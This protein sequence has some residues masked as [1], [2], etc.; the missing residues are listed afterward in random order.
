[1]PD[2][3]LDVPTSD[4]T[5][6]T[7]DV[8]GWIAGA[9]T[10]TTTILITRD[11]QAGSRLAAIDTELEQLQQPAPDPEQRPSRRLAE[12]NPNEARIRELHTERDTIAVGMTGG[13]LWVTVRALSYRVND[14]I[15]SDS[16]A[17]RNL[18]ALAAS[19]TVAAT[20]GGPGESLT[21]EQWDRLT[22]AIG[23]A[24]TVR[25]VNALTDLTLN[26]VVTPD[27]SQPASDSPDGAGSS[28]N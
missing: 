9:V 12:G 21:W 4:T 18:M 23:I 1:M 11:I 16:L 13:V 19:A 5:P 25:I 24:Q 3:N 27:F 26:R 20:P 22:E 2:T 10:P 28:A 15:R 14:G 8:E 17:E 7:F 6:G